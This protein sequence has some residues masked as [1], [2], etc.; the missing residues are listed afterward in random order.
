MFCPCARQA[1][2][3]VKT[4]LPKPISSLTAGALPANA[5]Q[6]LAAKM[7]PAASIASASG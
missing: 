5:E 1:W 3:G 2:T 4:G 7:L 6:V